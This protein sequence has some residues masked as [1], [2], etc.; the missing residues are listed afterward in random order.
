MRAAR[1]G[2]V[3]LLG[4]HAPMR[5]MSYE[6]T[7][8]ARSVTWSEV[9]H[10][11]RC[12]VQRL[13]AAVKCVWLA[14]T[15]PRRARTIRVTAHSSRSGGGSGR[16]CL[17][18]RISF[19]QLVS[20]VRKVQHSRSSRRR[21]ANSSSRPLGHATTRPALAALTQRPAVAFL[22]RLIPR[23]NSQ[24]RTPRAATAAPRAAPCG[25][26]P[27]AGRPAERHVVGGEDESAGLDGWQ[28][29]TTSRRAAPSRRRATA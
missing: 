4:G 14:W 3:P 13:E 28:W 6:L 24:R 11:L 23:H 21:E 26:A 12:H 5:S 7:L 29:R 17:G 1:S 10:G 18:C 15:R 22:Q 16:H 9:R 20:S 2:V 27:C 25:R 8:A 19:H